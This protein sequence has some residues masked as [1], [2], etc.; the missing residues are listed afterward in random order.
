MLP[1]QYLLLL[2]IFL[3]CKDVEE[4]LMIR[5][6]QIE[7][8]LFWLSYIFFGITTCWEGA[9]L[10]RDVLSYIL[11]EQRLDIFPNYLIFQKSG[12]PQTILLNIQY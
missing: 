12:L 11:K 9:A 6:F 10:N 8:C 7:F 2:L 5:L 4:L 1:S 3:H